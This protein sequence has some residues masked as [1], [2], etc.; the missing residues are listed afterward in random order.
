V[1]AL[2]TRYHDGG[3][4]R[5]AARG[6]SILAVITV[7]RGGR[8]VAAPAVVMSS[9]GWAMPRALEGDLETLG[10]WRFVEESLTRRLDDRLRPDNPDD[11][12]PPLDEAAIRGTFD[13]LVA[14]TGRAAA[15][16]PEPQV[17][18]ADL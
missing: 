18:A 4:E 14:R 5:P 16:G 6:E 9:F 11:P 17:C 12:P 2:L 15:V 8:P 7:D 1:A 10:H 3:L 13:W